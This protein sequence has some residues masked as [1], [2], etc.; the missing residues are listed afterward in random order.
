M[1]YRRPVRA[2]RIGVATN[3]LHA[4]VLNKY[5]VDEIYDALFVRPIGAVARWSA[6]VFD[7]E[8]IDGV[9]NG[10]GAMVGGWARG[11]RHLQTGFVM[12]Y[13]LGMLLGA[14]AAV[15][16]LLTR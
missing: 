10:V 14:V 7:A 6:R 2:E 8:V 9:V 11:L 3:P 12:N 15:A 4:L 5:Y 16:Y 13:A 1:Y